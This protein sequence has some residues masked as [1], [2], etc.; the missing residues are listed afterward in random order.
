MLRFFVHGYEHY[1]FFLLV[2]SII[3]GVIDAGSIA[4]FYPMISVG[5]NIN[6]GSIPY[7]G[8]IEYISSLIPMGSQFVHLGLLFILLTGTSLVLQLAYWKAGFIFQRELIVKTKKS[9]FS[10]I[11]SNDYRFFVD[12][13]QGD[14]INLFNQSPYYI[15]QTYDRLL[16][17]CTDLMTSVLVIVMLFLISPGGLIL[18]LIGGGI[19]YLIINSIS[20]NI[21]EKLGSLQISSGQSE[22]KVINE[23]ITGVKSIKSLHA[24]EHWGRQYIDALKVYWDKFADL[25]FIQRI[26][27][28]AINSLFYI[29]IGAI[30]LVLY[31]FYADNFLAIIPVLGT[32]AAGMMK[33]LPKA[34]NMGTYKMEL[35]NFYPHVITIYSTLQDSKYHDVVNGELTCKDI[36]SDIVLDNVSFSYGHARILN[37]VSMSITKGAMTA[38]VGHSGSGKSTIASLLLRLY[39]PGSGRI[40]VNGRDLKEYDMNT[41]RDIVGYVSQDPFVFNA[42]IREN[43]LFGGEFSDTEV[44][45]AAKS[46]H[47]H[48]FIMDLPDGY[49]TMV[50]DQGVTLSGGEKQRIVI[51]RAMIRRPEFLILDEATSALDNISEAAVQKAIDQVAKECT[52][53]VIAHRLTTIRNADKIVVIEKGRIVEEGRHEELIERKGRYWEMSMMREM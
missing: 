26:P 4:L 41:Y 42:S 17:L 46:A 14:L 12:S 3:I 36:S 29:S 15:Q 30:V 40:I 52:T 7:Y 53:L 31:I 45:Q 18:V 9:I 20:K 13:K 6:A 50:G 19:F 33:I 24:S 22:N 49:D 2:I 37:N 39:D 11:D 25:M 32:F 34:M 10:R 27:I 48:E 1:L 43:I 8:V 51:A 35:K 23:Y 47:A 44:I 38:L 28:I 16:C 5:F 21:S